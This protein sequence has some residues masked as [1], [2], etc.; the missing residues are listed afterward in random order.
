MS[1]VIAFGHGPLLVVHANVLVP[2]VRPTTFEFGSFTSAN[3]PAPSTN[4]HVP[5]AGKMGV[6]P[7]RKMLSWGTQ[8]STSGPAFAGKLNSL[9][10]NM[11]TLSWLIPHTP[12]SSVHTRMFSPTGRPSTAVVGLVASVK[13]AAP[14]N[15]LHTP[16][17]GAVGLLPA[18][19]VLVFGVH[20]S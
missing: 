13:F 16:L 7:A 14:W 4:V 17:P 15:T 10:M 9:K 1:L 18:N 5:E 20:C 2:I 6:L 12:F 11:L 8:I 19:T 3:R